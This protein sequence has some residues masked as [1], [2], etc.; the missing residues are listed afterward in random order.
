MTEQH[1]FAPETGKNLHH[2]KNGVLLSGSDLDVKV[3]FA[4]GGKPEY[5]EENPRSQ[6]EID[7]SQP[8]CGAKQ[9]T[10]SCRLVRGATDDHYANLTPISLPLPTRH[11]LPQKTGSALASIFVLRTCSKNPG[12]QAL[13]SSALSPFLFTITKLTSIFLKQ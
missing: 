11:S 8:T 10:P 13:P 5:P 12:I 9:S 1:Y 3:K 2:S 6:I 7:I 4:E